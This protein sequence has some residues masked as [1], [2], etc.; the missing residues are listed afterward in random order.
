MAY[1]ETQRGRGKFY[2]DLNQGSD[3]TIEQA[4]IKPILL[5]NDSSSGIDN[6]I[7]KKLEDTIKELQDSLQNVQNQYNDIK[8]KVESMEDYE[9]PAATTDILGGIKVGSGLEMSEDNHLN[10]DVETIAYNDGE[11]GLSATNVSGALFELTNRL[12]DVEERTLEVDDE[13][14]IFGIK[15][16]KE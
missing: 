10:A 4:Y 6:E 11:G 12:E 13:N 9:L 5:E 7:L 3:Q 8:I 15:G 1:D 14:L 16:V 2:S